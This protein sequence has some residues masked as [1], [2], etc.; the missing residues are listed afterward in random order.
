MI[1]SSVRT[2]EEVQVERD[3]HYAKWARESVENVDIRN[4][5]LLA[6]ETLHTL[7]NLRACSA[8]IFQYP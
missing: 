4:F 6:M 2:L 8:K 5:A 3:N 7:Y 1:H